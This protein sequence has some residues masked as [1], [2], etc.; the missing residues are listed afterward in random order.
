[1]IS[2]VLFNILM[3]IFNGILTIFRFKRSWN[4]ST[5]VICR[6]MNK[7]LSERKRQPLRY[8]CHKNAHVLNVNSAFYTIANL[9]FG[10][11]LSDIRFSSHYKISQGTFIFRTFLIII[12]FLISN[13]KGYCQ[14]LDFEKQQVKILSSHAFH[15]RGYVNHGDGLAAA[16]LSHKFR[17]NHLSAFGKDYFQYYD[18]EVNSFPGTMDLKIDN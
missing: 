15:G 16:Y 7:L 1:V 9:E 13:H 14:D 17:E 3:I 6:P 12:G 4:L 18:F 8:A 5:D 11:F 2:T 10:V